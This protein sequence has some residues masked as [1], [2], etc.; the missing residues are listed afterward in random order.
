[1]EGV[2]Y[3]I[4]LLR[5]VVL[6][7]FVYLLHNFK[8]EQNIL[9]LAV[10]QNLCVW[11]VYVYSDVANCQL[12]GHSQHL[13]I[14]LPQHVHCKCALLANQVKIPRTFF[15]RGSHVLPT[16]SVYKT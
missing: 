9:G 15:F 14:L 12:F 16:V 8:E 3:S 7:P 10:E 1:M 13:E 2:L 5:K 4:V 6:E 11:S